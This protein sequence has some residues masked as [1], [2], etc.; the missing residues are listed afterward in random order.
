MI[1]IWRSLEEEICQCEQGRASQSVSRN[2]QNQTKTS[3]NKTPWRKDRKQKLKQTKKKETKTKKGKRGIIWLLH[4]YNIGF[5]CTQ[6]LQTRVQPHPTF[7]RNTGLTSYWWHFSRRFT[8]HIHSGPTITKELSQE[9][10]AHCLI[11]I[12]RSGHL[13][14][15]SANYLDTH[16]CALSLHC[17]EATNVPPSIPNIETGL[18]RF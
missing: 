13:S 17:E 2:H 12:T 11:Q 6:S 7:P 4:L 15:I 1:L 18:F 5:M 8:E 14:K 10:M 16:W 3:Q 9:G